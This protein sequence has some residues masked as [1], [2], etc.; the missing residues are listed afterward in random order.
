M[1]LRVGLYELKKTIVK[2]VDIIGAG[3]GGLTLAI[4]LKQRGIQV[5]VY[6]QA[7][8]LKAVGAGINLACN[9][10][11]VYDA[12]GIRLDIEAAGHLCQRMQVT[13]Q[14]LEP[15]SNIDIQPFSRR[16][17]VNRLPSIKILVA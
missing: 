5:R 13:D 16:F 7:Q 9:A 1:Q 14:K 17:S 4:A 2:S 12:L 10:M 11:Q 8:E 3:I 15:L 6:E